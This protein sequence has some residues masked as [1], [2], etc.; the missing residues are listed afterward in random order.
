MKTCKVI[1]NKWI[2]E[3]DKDGFTL[4]DKKQRR[5]VI[6]ASTLVQDEYFFVADEMT[7][8][9]N[10]LGYIISQRWFGALHPVKKKGKK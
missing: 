1:G 3:I 5:W 10:Q 2:L 9:S 4:W 8:E 6:D 7:Q